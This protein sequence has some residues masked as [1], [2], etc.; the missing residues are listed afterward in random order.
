MMP[1]PDAGQ[2]GS[3]AVPA[4]DPGSRPT[5]A[6][7]QP[8][9]GGALQPSA[10]ETGAPGG[11]SPTAR[12]AP[13]PAAAAPA[14]RSRVSRAT[15]LAALVL[16]PLA[17]DA[18]AVLLRGA[19][20]LYPALGINTATVSHSA[21]KFWQLLL[22]WSVHPFSPAGVALALT[23]AAV[24]LLCGH[25]IER[26]LGGAHLLAAFLGGTVFETIGGALLAPG[27]PRFG[28]GGAACSVALFFTLEAWNQRV[29]GPF[30][31]ALA[32]LVA[33]LGVA[34]AQ[35]AASFGAGGGEDGVW[36]SAVVLAWPVLLFRFGPVPAHRRPPPAEE[37]GYHPIDFQTDDEV[38]AEVDRLLTRIAA[39]GVA[40]LS[41]V[42]RDFLARASARLAARSGAAGPHQ[43]AT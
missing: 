10:G 37:T 23:A 17:V 16:L 19:P 34:C 15:V 4:P 42:E 41:A 28:A 25:G 2:P 18:L 9:D 31:G 26:R 35:L 36:A 38:R 3:A 7:A 12:Q 14:P 1:P 5:D 6:P 13:L 43:G 39:G 11:A 30:P 21:V 29:L 33:A 40:R 22:F 24:T 8:P 20:P 27:E 32:G